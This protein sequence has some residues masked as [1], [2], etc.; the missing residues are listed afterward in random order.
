VTYDA[1]VNAC[2]YPD[3][4][5]IDPICLAEQTYEVNVPA[6]E[7]D[8]VEKEVAIASTQIQL[9]TSNDGRLINIEDNESK[10]DFSQTIA[11]GWEL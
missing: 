5:S 2:Y 9:E 8:S 11:M 1:T 10:N 6:P 7:F 3:V 4:D